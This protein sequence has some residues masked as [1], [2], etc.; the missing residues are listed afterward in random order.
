MQLSAVRIFVRDLDVAKTLYENILG[1]RLKGDGRKF[2]YCLFETGSID[3]VV[4]SVPPD[5][6]EDEQVLVGRFTG[7]SFSTSDAFATYEQLSALGVH[8]TGAPERQV[9]GGIL[10][11]LQDSSGNQLQIIQYRS[12]A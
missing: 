3:V 12:A 9:W 8:F 5:A 7:L 6:P 11:T 4:E 1:L 10:A 2:G